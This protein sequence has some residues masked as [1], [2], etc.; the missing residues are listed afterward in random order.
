MAVFAPSSFAEM[1]EMLAAALYSM[2]GP[3][4]LRYPRG[5]QGAYSKSAGTSPSALLRKGTDVTFVSYGMMI[6]NIIEAAEA[7]EKLGVS[8]EIIKLNLINPLDTDAVL[9]SLKKTGVLLVAE[10]V[11]E[12]GSVGSRILAACAE[13]KVTLKAARAL[14]L[15]DGLIPQG[16][17]EEL[18]GRFGLDA[19]SI[20]V[21]ATALLEKTAV[22]VQ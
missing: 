11:C 4:A 5:G 16:T 10:D 6:N 17:P 20:A 21:A 19:A 9:A 1:R 22:E 2:K 8:A 15:G 7:L 13:H 18:C 12:Q 3:V 14:N